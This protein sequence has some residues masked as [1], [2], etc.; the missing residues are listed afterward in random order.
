MLRTDPV[1]VRKIA[2]LRAFCLQILILAS[3]E[4]NFGTR[5]VQKLS[6]PY[7]SVGS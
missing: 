3:R 4:S 6:Q 7:G 2:A 5:G 1:S